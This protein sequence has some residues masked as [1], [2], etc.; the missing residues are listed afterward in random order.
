MK[1]YIVKVYNIINNCTFT[2]IVT[3]VDE[4][5]ALHIAKLNVE[6]ATRDLRTEDNDTWNPGFIKYRIA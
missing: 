2:E 4:A 6:D 3:A 1:I 5:D